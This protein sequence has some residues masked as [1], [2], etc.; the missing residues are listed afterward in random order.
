MNQFNDRAESNHAGAGVAEAAGS[1]QQKRRADA[2]AAANAEIFSDLGNGV[3]FGDGVAPKFLLNG[4][5]V[6]PEQV[7]NFQCRRYRQ[8]AQR[9]RIPT[10]S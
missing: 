8:C 10:L 1:Q 6:I 4:R 7:E 3:D 5:E 2:F 9:F